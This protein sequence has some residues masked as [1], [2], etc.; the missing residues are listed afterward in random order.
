MV[1]YLLNLRDFTL[2]CTIVNQNSRANNDCVAQRGVVR[3]NS[4]CITLDGRVNHNHVGLPST[5][6]DTFTLLE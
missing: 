3:R 2:E 6:L 1:T 5:Q 4:C